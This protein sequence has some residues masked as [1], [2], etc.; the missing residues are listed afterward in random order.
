MDTGK[1]NL[2]L[3]IRPGMTNQDIE[4]M[5]KDMEEGILSQIQANQQVLQE[6]KT[7][8]DLKVIIIL[9]NPVAVYDKQIREILMSIP[10]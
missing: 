1:Y 7:S 9:T 3:D 10:W 6:S 4:A 8:W 2:Q 5:R